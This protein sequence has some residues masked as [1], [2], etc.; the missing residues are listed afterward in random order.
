MSGQDPGGETGVQ[1]VLKA[2]AQ[3]PLREL[4]RQLQLLIMIVVSSYCGAIGACAA[5][6]RVQPGQLRVFAIIVACSV[7]AVELTRRT[8][9][10]AGPCGDVYAIWDLPAAVLLP[11]LYAL[12]VPIPRLLVMQFQGRREP[13]RRRACTAAVLGLS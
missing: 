13:P 11:P 4:P 1:A 10:R 12:L 9:E 6:T 8:G 7:A 2:V 3:R 5:T